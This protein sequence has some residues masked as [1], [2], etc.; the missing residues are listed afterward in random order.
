MTSALDRLASRPAPEEDLA[1]GGPLVTLLP[2]QPGSREARY[3]HLLGASFVS[4]SPI[5]E[6]SPAAEDLAALVASLERRISSLEERVE[7]L[8][9]PT[10]PM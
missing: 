7:R 2:R 5:A 10:E 3:T 4:P 9:T 1:L 6:T 8:E